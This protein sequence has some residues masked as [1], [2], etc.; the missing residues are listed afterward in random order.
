MANLPMMIS[1]RLRRAGLR[2]IYATALK[3]LL[4]PN[5]KVVFYALNAQVFYYPDQ[6]LTAVLAPEHGEHL[7][8]LVSLFPQDV[9]A[10]AWDV[11]FSADIFPAEK[12]LSS[13][14]NWML[15]QIGSVNPDVCNRN[16]FILS[17][18]FA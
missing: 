8:P 1:T 5:G 14:W 9:L 18:R 2:Q 6:L 11:G 15:A 7:I 4:K 17:N 12:P 10:A 13:S 16:I 3:P